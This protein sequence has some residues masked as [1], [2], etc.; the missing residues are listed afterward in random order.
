HR[1]PPRQM[2]FPDQ[3]SALQQLAIRV[4]HRHLVILRILRRHLERGTI[5]IKRQGIRRHP[6]RDRI[7][8]IDIHLERRPGTPELLTRNPREP[9]SP[10]RSPP[11]RAARPS[12][13]PPPPAAPLS[14]K[15]RPPLSPP[16][17]PAPSNPGAPF[18]PRAPPHR[19]LRVRLHR[20]RRPGRHGRLRLQHR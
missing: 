13:L 3:P 1:R 4:S 17:S 19:L 9:P 6:V 2:L 20:R 8:I 15:P 14:K 11:C 18:P 10:P 7:R 16:P 5:Q 12:S